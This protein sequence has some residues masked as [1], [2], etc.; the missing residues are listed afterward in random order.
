MKQAASMGVIVMPP[1]PAF[2]MRPK[3]IEE[4]V[5]HTAGRALDLIGI[6]TP[7]L[8]RW[9]AERRKASGAT[10]PRESAGK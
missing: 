7:D 3:S 5:D 4:I 2:Y 10:P 9:D 8:H 6:Q 1:V